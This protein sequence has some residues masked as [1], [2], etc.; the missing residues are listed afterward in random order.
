MPLKTRKWDAAKY[1]RTPE[2]IQTYLSDAYDDGDP[3]YIALALGT[4][5]RAIGMS[6]VA[7]ETNL[8][9]ESLY[10]SLSP[11]G[12]PSI[13]TV[14]NVA[15]VADMKLVFVP[16]GA[17][18]QIAAKSDYY[19]K[20]FTCN[21]A[22]YA[23]TTSK[24]DNKRLKIFS[25]ASTNDERFSPRYTRTRASTFGHETPAAYIVKAIDAMRVNYV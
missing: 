4:V 5:A 15:K 13:L 19:A 11:K 2:D 16:V 6:R 22:Q 3:R 7:K 21:D 25:T 24:L 23:S 8:S 12:N 18:K 10:K 14:C 17:Q 20:I 1:L 9:R